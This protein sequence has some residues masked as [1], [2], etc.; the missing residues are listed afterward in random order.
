[1][2]NLRVIFRISSLRLT[3]PT[4]KMCHLMR[5]IISSTMVHRCPEKMCANRFKT[6]KTEKNRRKRKTACPDAPKN[7]NRE[8]YR[9]RSHFNLLAQQIKFNIHLIFN[10]KH[11]HS[12]DIRTKVT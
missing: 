11:V 4:F 2:R 5:A 12:R 10:E 6:Q 9:F 7:Y 8:G 3:L 1:M